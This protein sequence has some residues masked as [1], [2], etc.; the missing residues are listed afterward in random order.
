MQE[1]AKPPVPEAQSED[2]RLS[3]LLMQ[4][5]NKH[6]LND[7]CCKELMRHFIH[8]RCPGKIDVVLKTGYGVTID[9]SCDVKK[10]PCVGC[11]YFHNR[12]QNVGIQ[13]K[14]HKEMDANMEALRQSWDLIKMMF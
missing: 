14:V 7:V 10:C 12:H 6:E 13:A 8:D 3:G 1:G 11:Y 4:L 2:Q 5:N 9:R